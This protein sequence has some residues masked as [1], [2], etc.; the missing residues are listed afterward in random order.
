MTPPT[1]IPAKPRRFGRGPSVPPLP[2]E[3]ALVAVAYSA[4]SWVRLT[5]DVAIDIG[6]LDVEAIVVSDGNIGATY[7][8][9]G[10]PTQPDAQSVQVSLVVVGPF[11][12]PGI[13]VL[14]VADGAGIVRASGGIP[15]PGV[16]GVGIPFS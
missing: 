12:E 7:H 13:V 5:F 8:G 14:T 1:I 3:P 9:V 15:W 10:T 2:A 4:E 6:S 16:P 11:P